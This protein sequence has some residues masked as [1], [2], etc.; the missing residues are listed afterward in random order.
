MTP[1]INQLLCYAIQYSQIFEKRNKKCRVSYMLH[2]FSFFLFYF[3]FERCSKH[4]F[5]VCSVGFPIPRSDIQTT[6]DVWASADKSMTSPHP[7]RSTFNG[8][9][10]CTRT[11][12]SIKYSRSPPYAESHSLTCVVGSLTRTESV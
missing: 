6:R 4:V 5:S 7:Q 11:T 2:L 1:A 8:R 9:K 10:L 3:K 12:G